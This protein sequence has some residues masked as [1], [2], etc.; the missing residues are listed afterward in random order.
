[1][2]GG[3][4]SRLDMHTDEGPEVSVFQNRTR[5]LIVRYEDDIVIESGMVAVA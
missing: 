5:T 1:M 2:L 4:L 3:H